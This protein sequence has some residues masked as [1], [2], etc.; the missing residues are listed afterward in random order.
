MEG[1]TSYVEVRSSKEHK[2]KDLNL[3][4]R[5]KLIPG[6][7]IVRIE[8]PL[9]FANI[10]Q[11]KR[12]F[13]RIETLGD[14]RERAAPSRRRRS[15]E[16]SSSDSSAS[17]PTF[18]IVIHCRNITSM[19]ASSIQ[20]LKEMVST[21]KT[22]RIHVCFVKLRPQLRE[23][24]LRADIVPA[25]REDTMLFKS[26]HEAVQ[27]CIK[28]SSMLDHVTV[29]DDNKQQDESRIQERLDAIAETLEQSSAVIMP[30]ERKKEKKII[31]DNDE[32]DELQ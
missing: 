28:T 30:P 10:A 13:T 29:E 19:D 6:V 2:D 24:F 17:V 3:K 27:Y 11:I 8:E 18:A 16:R 22:R 26:T 1:T 31:D 9:Y 12:L 21:Y 32:D 14:P 4:D 23:R 20:A 25:N 7:V 15:L 5:I